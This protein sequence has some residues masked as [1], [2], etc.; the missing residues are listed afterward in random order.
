MILSI[1]DLGSNSARMDIVQIDEKSET[2]K[3]LERCR[4]LVR[5]SEGMNADGCLQP[6]AIERSIDA[7]IEFKEIMRGYNAD[8]CIAAATAAVR[9]AGNS[10][11]FCLRVLEETG[12]SL[13]VIPGEQEAEYDF[14]GVMS[15]LDIDNCVITDTGGGSTEF[16]LV[17]DGEPLAR[18]SIPVGAVNMTEQFLSCGETYEAMDALSDYIKSQLDKI[19]WLDDAEGL[20]IV[21]L[22]GSVY[23]L[24]AVYSDAPGAERGAL[25]GVSISADNVKSTFK[26]LCSLTPSERTDAGVEQGRED[27]IIA[28]IM[29]TAELAEKISSD[30]VIVSFAGLKEG[31][32]AEFLENLGI[33]Y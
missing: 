32:L 29:P 17:S 11:E 30:S 4:E 26:K 1:I 5:L 13:N 22:G 31:I 6:D 9:K 20:P 23:N 7:L 19:G 28:G 24:A 27:T 14:R 25:H 12:I 10:D 16:I 3:Y 15:S 18:T 8:D 2:H 21:G 33:P